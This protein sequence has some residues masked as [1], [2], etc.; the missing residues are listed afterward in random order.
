MKTSMTPKRTLRGLA[1]EMEAAARAGEVAAYERLLAEW[2]ALSNE[3]GRFL[4]YDA[5]N[6]LAVYDGTGIG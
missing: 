4:Y 5:A 3:Q 1:Q 2:K 6:D